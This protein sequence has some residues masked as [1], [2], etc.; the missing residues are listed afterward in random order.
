MHNNP[1]RAVPTTWILLNSQS[2]VDLIAN[3]KI[4][5]NI[6]VVRD[7]DAIQVYCNSGS[8]L[9]NQIGELHGYNTVWYK[10]TGI[11]NIIVMSRVTRNYQVALDCE[12]RDFFLDDAF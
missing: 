12:G 7:E 2:T 11:A 10:P 9:I 6:R 3:P 8:N 4:L 1:G 5:E